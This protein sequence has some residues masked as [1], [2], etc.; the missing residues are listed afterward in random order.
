MPQM[1]IGVL[2]PGAMG[3]TVA[4]GLRDS[5][6]QVGWVSAGRSPETQQRAAGLHSFASIDEIA[7]WAD[8][9]I[10]ICPPHGA[11]ALAQ[12]V[13]G[14]GFTG[15]FVDAN[16]LAPS[17]S[18]KI[19]D[20]LGAGAFVDGG[21]IGPPAIKPGITRLYLSG[22]HAA[23]VSAWFS[24]GNLQA[25]ALPMTDA[26]NASV[27]AS[28]LKMAYAAYSKGASALLLSV[29]ALAEAGGVSEA[30]HQEWAISSPDLLK[31]SEYTAAATSGKAW[32][33]VGEMLE[34]SETYSNAGLPDSFHTAAAAIYERM[35][36]LKDLPPQSLEVV[37]A[38]LL[39]G[40][41]SNG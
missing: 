26:P 40:K 21:I 14:T 25:I 12:A 19:A 29:N 34:I 6:H 16:A 20:L 13:H 39:E 7:G 9:L 2:H 3:I 8:A 18:L 15:L 36:E 10:S 33:F 30:L 37:I 22:H 5:G 1:N 35:Q 11:L 32:R 31:R 38:A 28:T 24:A 4:Q 23:A 41:Q 27:A 17:T